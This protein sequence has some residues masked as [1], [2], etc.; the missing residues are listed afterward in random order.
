MILER[1][2]DRCAANS[3]GQPLNCTQEEM[4]YLIEIRFRLLAHIEQANYKHCSEFNKYLNTN[5]QTVHVYHACCS[6]ENVILNENT[7][8]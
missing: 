1:A 3:S 5:W 6:D 4:V 7:K 8:S 2:S